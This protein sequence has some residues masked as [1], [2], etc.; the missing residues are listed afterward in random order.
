MTVGVKPENAY[1]VPT[2]MS[3]VPELVFKKSVYPLSEGDTVATLRFVRTGIVLNAGSNADGDN[4]A[5]TGA[6]IYV[7]QPEYTYAGNPLNKG[8]LIRAITVQGTSGLSRYWK[9]NQI[10]GGCESWVQ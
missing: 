1:K 6:T 3:P 2:E 4:A 8:S 9:C 10:K 5:M 7:W